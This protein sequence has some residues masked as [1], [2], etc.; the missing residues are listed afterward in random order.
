MHEIIR[1]GFNIVESDVFTIG[2]GYVMD[3]HI[4]EY[5]IQE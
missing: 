5:V 2:G 3:D 1:F 4:L